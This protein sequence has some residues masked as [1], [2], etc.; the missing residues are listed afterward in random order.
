ME[1]K[2]KLIEC[3][4][5]SEYNITLAARVC[6]KS[7]DESDSKWVP[8]E[9]AQL[10]MGGG[11]ITLNAPMVRIE[12]GPNDEKLL[13]KLMTNGHSST[14]RFAYAHFH[15][16]NISICAGRQLNRI[17]HAGQ[18][19]LSQRYVSQENSKF[20][21]PVEDEW[22]QNELQKLYNISDKFYSEAISRGFKKEEAR[23]GKL[24]ANT[25]EL[26]FSGNF[27]MFKHLFS[28]RLNEKV[29][30]ETRKICAEM[31]K[32]LYQKAPIVF[33]EDYQKV[34]DLGL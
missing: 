12:L 5:N 18:L 13:R 26:H 31:C 33:A 10:V 27:Q 6:Y 2:V 9:N 28:I 21:C 3:T 32:I 23:Y 34:L 30:L 11:N 4:E 14:L 1:P 8:T 29:M 16:S 24:M 7:D 22:F 25:T 17:A 15:V 20:I 19:E